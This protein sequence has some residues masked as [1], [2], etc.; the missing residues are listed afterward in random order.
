MLV[1]SRRLMSYTGLYRKILYEAFSTP[2]QKKFSFLSLHITRIFINYIGLYADTY[3]VDYRLHNYVCKFPGCETWDLIGL[4]LL[5]YVRD[6][7]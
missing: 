1:K 5:N 3:I 6:H 7:Y 2:L 4:V